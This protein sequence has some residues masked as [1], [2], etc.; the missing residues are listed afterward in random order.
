MDRIGAGDAFL[1]V[2][3]LCAV[4]GAPLDVIG[5]VG[6]AA[7]ARAVATVGNAA[8]IERIPLLKQIE[9]LMK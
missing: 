1:S 3:S 4:Q 5:F 7:G 8:P 6:N 2:S 9:T